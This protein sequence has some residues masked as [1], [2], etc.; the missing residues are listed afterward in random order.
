MPLFDAPPVVCMMSNDAYY[1]ALSAQPNRLLINDLPNQMYQILGGDPTLLILYNTEAFSVKL[2]Q[3]TL[4]AVLASIGT[5][6]FEEILY[7]II[8]LNPKAPE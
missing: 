4:D 6:A 8:G 7:C 2:Y 3:V 1:H 5:C